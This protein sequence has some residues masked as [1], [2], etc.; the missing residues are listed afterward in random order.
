MLKI[1]G[2]SEEDCKHI[3]ERFFRSDSSRHLQ[4]KGLGLALVQAIVEAH[5]WT[6]T[7]DSKPGQGSVFSVLIRDSEPDKSGTQPGLIAAT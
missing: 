4:G 3:F 5:G 6:I 7:V 1:C 2:I